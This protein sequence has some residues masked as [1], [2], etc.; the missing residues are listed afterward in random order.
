MIK[1][2]ATDAIKRTAAPTSSSA[3]SGADRWSGEE[4][5]RLTRFTEPARLLPKLS[6][7]AILSVAPS[8]HYH[9][10]GVDHSIP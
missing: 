4:K 7:L 9:L 5:R 3:Q 8:R 6:W 1:I 10:C 2:E